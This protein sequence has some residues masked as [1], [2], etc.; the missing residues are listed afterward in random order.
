M[1]R[2]NS[3]TPSDLVFS[4]SSLSVGFFSSAEYIES[5]DFTTQ[6]K[7]STDKLDEENSKSGDIPEFF[8][9]KEKESE[10]NKE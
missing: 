5:K 8:L 10:E 3:G 2:K 4:S 6:E 1:S 7:E 9:D